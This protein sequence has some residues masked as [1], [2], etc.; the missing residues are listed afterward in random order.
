MRVPVGIVGESLIQT[1]VKVLVVRE[2]D[3]AADIVELEVQLAS[4][5]FADRRL[6]TYKAF[7]SDVRR[8]ET[9]RLFVPIHNYP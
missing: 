7:W 9:A 3:M 1:V 4:R 8:R 5:R 2:D 6:S